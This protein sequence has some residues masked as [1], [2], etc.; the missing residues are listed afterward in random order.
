M[1][2]EEI[3][4]HY[5]RPR[6]TGKLDTE[7]SAE[8]ANETC[9]DHTEVYLKVENGEI[10]EMRHE[11]EGCAIC[12]AATSILSEKISGMEVEEAKNL[13]RDRMLD[14]LEMDISPM[15]V[16]CALLGMKTVQKALD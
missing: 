13:D 8:G 5:R 11:T 15:R 1:Y 9:G 3:M 12:T 14:V 6:N 4:D 2:R 16:K 10:L 7:F